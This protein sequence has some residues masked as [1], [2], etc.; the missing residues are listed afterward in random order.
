[1][2]TELIDRGHKAEFRIVEVVCTEGGQEILRE[3][4]SIGL[5]GKDSPKEVLINIKSDCESRAR[6][7]LKRDKELDE[8]LK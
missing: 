2:K 6:A 1:M 8:L 5:D 3:R 7:R 4:H